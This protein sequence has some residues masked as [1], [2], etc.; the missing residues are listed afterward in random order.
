MNY[1][2]ENIIRKIGFLVKRV[3]D[4]DKEIDST[5][6]VEFGE[7][8]KSAKFSP[9][10][11]SEIVATVFELNNGIPLLTSAWDVKGY[12]FDLAFSIGKEHKI[13]P[14]EGCDCSE[15]KAVQLGA[16]ICGSS[17][18]WLGCPLCGRITPRL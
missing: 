15:D 18:C 2:H 8:L 7:L 10:H 14:K 9:E 11:A 16:I 17:Q 3:A 6:I 12:L 5:R 13:F 4:G 1:I